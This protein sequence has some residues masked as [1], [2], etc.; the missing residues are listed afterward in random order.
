ML[1]HF[2]P[3]T[4]ETNPNKL[5][6][7]LFELNNEWKGGEVLCEDDVNGDMGM[8]PVETYNAVF[9]DIATTPALQQHIVHDIETAT[10]DIDPVT[11]F[12]TGHHIKVQ[13]NPITNP[14]MFVIDFVIEKTDGKSGETE[15]TGKRKSVA[16]AAASAPKKTK[17]ESVAAR[18]T[19]DKSQWGRE[20][21]QLAHI[22]MH[23]AFN[24]KVLES[25][26]A[27]LK[28]I[29]EELAAPHI[30]PNKKK[31]TLQAASARKIDLSAEL[32]KQQ[33]LVDKLT[34]ASSSAE[35]AGPLS[36]QLKLLDLG[37]GIPSG[38]AH[39]KA[40]GAV[41]RIS[42][43][44][45]AEF[46]CGPPPSISRYYL[47]PSLIFSRSS[48]R[49]DPLKQYMNKILS[50]FASHASRI[51][52][53][54]P[55]TDAGVRAALKAKIEEICR[56]VNSSRRISSKASLSGFRLTGFGYNAKLR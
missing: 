26:K 56:A 51:S 50:V 20:G 35:H 25:E 30:L 13:F 21:Y 27:K 43:R 3:N 14:S 10:A 2:I 55:D 15:S 47:S 5:F 1:V 16:S 38:S 28:A 49:L 11:L 6:S 52:Q 36:S 19:Q 44:L 18:P 54:H 37:R 46:E 8:I 4:D 23:E 32:T 29:R 31:A 48:Y 7:L 33:K 39:M 40:T 17:H 45:C 22:T 34:N 41:L 12:D 53:N 9:R 42:W 24:A